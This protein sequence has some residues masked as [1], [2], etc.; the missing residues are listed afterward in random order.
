[1]NR[2]V[3]ECL[4]NAGRHAPGE[5]ITL[6]VDWQPGEVV[7]EASNPA[8]G[9]VPSTPGRGVTGMRHRAELLGGAF[10]AGV[11]DGRF[12][13]RVALPAARGGGR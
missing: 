11:T 8:A 5:P 12:E 4:T 9:R 3:R 2:I 7:V 6:R 13:I 1:V 10:D